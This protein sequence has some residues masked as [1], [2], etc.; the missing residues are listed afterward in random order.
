[1]IRH[2]KCRVVKFRPPGRH[3]LLIP[4]RAY[5]L[6]IPGLY[7]DIVSLRSIK[8]YGRIRSQH[9][10]RDPV[11]SGN[12]CHPRGSYL[13]CRVTIGGYPVTAYEYG[14]DLPLLHKK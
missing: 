2:I 1:M 12:Y 11:I 3:R 10:E 8:I 6:R 14:L 9:I 7:Y 5:L 4:E 13:I